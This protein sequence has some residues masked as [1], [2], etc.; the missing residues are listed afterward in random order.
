MRH[1]L[2]QTLSILR[3]LRAALRYDAQAGQWS[4]A[5]SRV[6]AAFLRSETGRK[7]DSGMVHYVLDAT[8]SAVTQKG[9]PYEVGTANGIRQMWVYL[10]TLSANGAAPE[11][12]S[13]QV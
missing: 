11:D 6:W 4:E 9:G 13:N 8:Q 7:L 3:K 12:G 10:T 1:I 2:S 5:D